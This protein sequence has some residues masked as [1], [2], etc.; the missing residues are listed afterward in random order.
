MANLMGIRGVYIEKAELIGV[1]VK[2]EF[3]NPKLPSFWNAI[4]HISTV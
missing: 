4:S 3:E 2:A 1:W